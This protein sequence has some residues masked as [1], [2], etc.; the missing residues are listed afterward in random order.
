[1]LNRN[2]TTPSELDYR[3]IQGRGMARFPTTHPLLV[4]PLLQS[5]ASKDDPQADPPDLTSIQPNEI[6]PV[7]RALHR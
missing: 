6:E 4:G 3:G 7:T 5:L 2:E 1:M